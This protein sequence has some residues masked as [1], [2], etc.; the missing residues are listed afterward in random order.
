MSVTL[1]RAE[2]SDAEWIWKMQVDAFHDLYEKYRDTETSPAMES[3]AKVLSKIEQP[4][5]YFYLIDAQGSTVGAIRVVDSKEIGKPKRIAPCFILKEHRNKGF[6]QAAI[7]E[8]ERIHGSD[9]WELDTIMQEKGHCHL[10][11]KLGYQASGKTEKINE[12]LTIV[13][14]KK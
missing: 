10:Y 2:R 8:A 9:N 5:T 14:Y 13:F 3:L 4:S 1:R 12:R 11:E 7:L 6:A